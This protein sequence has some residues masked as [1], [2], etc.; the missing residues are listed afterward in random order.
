MPRVTLD[1]PDLTLPG[2]ASTPD[3]LAREL[4]LAAAIQWY[5]RGQVSQ[6]KAA[7]IAGMSR[8]DFIDELARQK[9]EVVQID[10]DELKDE[11]ARE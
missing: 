8:A 6:S 5:S 1:L 10:L 7:E 9:V 11:L 2:R 4:R 3:A